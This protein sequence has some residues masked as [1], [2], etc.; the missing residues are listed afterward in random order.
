M[1]TLNLTIPQ[2]W[3]EL[4]EQQLV[5]ISRLIA[6]KLPAAEILTRCAIHFTGLKLLRQNPVI[7]KEN[8]R[9]KLC[10]MFRYQKSKQTHFI[11]LETFA[12]MVNHLTWIESGITLFKSLSQIKGYRSKNFKLYETT[13]EEYLV[14]DNLYLA[15][16]QTGKEEYINKL[17]AIFYRN[18]KDTWNEGKDL[19]RWE[20]RFKRVSLGEKYSVYLWF[21]GVKSWIIEKYPYVF[22]PSEGGP[23]APETSIMGI[24]A[25]LNEGDVVKNPVIKQTYLNEALDTLNRKAKPAL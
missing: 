4:S 1:N 18:E 24:L 12:D 15:Y 11:D 19:S 6:E 2:S 3:K 14:A 8:Q 17:T 25:A 13:L 22:T 21:T 20:Q 16:T 23:I 10:Y 9:D 5:Y 7:I